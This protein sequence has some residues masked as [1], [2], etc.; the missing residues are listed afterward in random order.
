MYRFVPTKRRR[1]GGRRFSHVVVD[2]V[3]AVVNSVR[4]VMDVV[5]LS[6]FEGVI[7]KYV[8]LRPA[9]TSTTRAADSEA[10][11]IERIKVTPSHQSIAS[12]TLDRRN[13]S[14]R[15]FIHL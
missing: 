11:L 14:I 8:V 15:I 6:S 7:Y 3:E 10:C 12:L 1:A 4:R 13:V 9:S 5:F 2:R